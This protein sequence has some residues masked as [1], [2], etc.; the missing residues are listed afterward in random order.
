MIFPHVIPDGN[1]FSDKKT[2][3]KVNLYE[4]HVRNYPEKVQIS[5]SRPIDSGNL[6]SVK[7]NSQRHRHLKKMAGEVRVQVSKYLPRA[8]KEGAF[9]HH[10]MVRVKNCTNFTHPPHGT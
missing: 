6:K 9:A 10:G 4:C 3:Q 1:H 8:L 5:N 7:V 2:T